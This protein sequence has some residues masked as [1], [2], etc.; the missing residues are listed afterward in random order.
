MAG[1]ERL[2]HLDETLSRISTHH[3]KSSDSHFFIEGNDFYEILKGKKRYHCYANSGSMVWR[4]NAPDNI[5]ESAITA[6]GLVLLTEE[7]LY[8]TTIKG[9]G[10]LQGHFSEYLEF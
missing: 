9:K 1:E 10:A 4:F 7:T 8:Y 6:H 3:I 2:H 5:R